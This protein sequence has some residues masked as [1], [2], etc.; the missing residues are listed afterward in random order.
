MKQLRHHEN[1]LRSTIRNLRPTHSIVN[2]AGIE[3]VLQVQ[4]VL[5]AGRVALCPVVCNVVF[6]DPEY[7]CQPNSN[8]TFLQV[9]LSTTPSRNQPRILLTSLFQCRDLCLLPRDTEC[10]QFGA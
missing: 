3:R 2:T 5:E 7:R 10:V 6:L 1:L 4:S 9:V 8:T